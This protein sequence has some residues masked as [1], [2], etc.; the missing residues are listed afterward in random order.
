MRLKMHARLCLLA[1]LAATVCTVTPGQNARGQDSSR[2]EVNEAGVS[3]VYRARDF[4]KMTVERGERRTAEEAG[5]DIPVD[6]LPAYTCFLLQDKRPLPALAAGPRYFHE[7]KSFVCLFPLADSSVGDFGRAYPQLSE[8]AGELRRLLRARP[9]M[10]AKR[11]EYGYWRGLPD[12][13][14]NN[15]SESLLARFQYL[16]FP[17]L[18]GILFLTQ[19]SQEAEPNPANNEELTYNFQGLTRDGR[20][21]VAARFAV[22]HPSLPKGID[23]VNRAGMDKRL[24]YLRRDERKLKRLAE[25]SFRPSLRSLKALLSSIEIK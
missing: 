10:P 14:L 18:S 13:P 3:F 1:A 25:S 17:H 12:M 22:T 7:A 16:D 5:T 2:R 24:L 11:D 6:V 19:Y 4:G 9:A 21:Y 23:F 20:Y 15:A 8:A